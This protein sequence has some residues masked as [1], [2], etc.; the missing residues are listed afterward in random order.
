MTNPAQAI[1]NAWQDKNLQ[2][3]R[4]SLADG[5]VWHEKPAQQP[6]L[7]VNKVV[8]QWEKDLDG[9]ENIKVEVLESYN[10]G[11]VHISRWEA[12]FDKS[13]HQHLHGVFIIKVDRDN[14]IIEFRQWYMKG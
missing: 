14:K 6:I 2:L 7:G 3:L 11:L 9:Q 12:E 13:G 1:I 8:A 10:H 4:V 5:V